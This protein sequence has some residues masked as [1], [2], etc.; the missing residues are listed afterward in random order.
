MD[1][2]DD[3]VIGSGLAALGTVLGLGDK[4]R[5]LVLGGAAEGAFSH[6]DARAAVPCAY[7]GLG[8]LGGYWHGVIPMAQQHDIAGADP[9]TFETLL[10]RFYPRA[11]IARHVGQA[12]LFVPWRPIRPAQELTLLTQQ[13][14]QTLT[15]RAA[16]VERIE[17]GP[18]PVRVRSTAGEH[19]ARRV[20]VAA[21]AMHTPGLL[22]RSFGPA[23]QR[24]HVADHVLCYVGQVDGVAAPRTHI[25]R[26]GV[27]FPASVDAG[28][29]A[30]YTIRPARFSFRQLDHGIEQR[31]AFGLPTGN[32]VAKIMRSMSPGLL[33]EAFYNRFGIFTRAPRYSIYAQTPV[34]R[35][36]ALGEGATPLSPDMAR[37]QA[38]GESARQRQP[39]AGATLS[40]RPDLY[41]PGIHLH[42]SVDL[43]AMAQAG[44]NRPGDPV[45]VVDASALSRIGPGH[46]SFRMLCAAYQRALN[47]D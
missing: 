23:L 45:Q 25:T 43:T 11:D 12:A 1:E 14:P 26:D 27:Y 22:A 7:S 38:A 13:R 41:I 44:I 31:A 24:S 5:V 42:H 21:G 29:T 46:H 37:I 17:A 33:A 35:A 30:L 4:R 9:L 28:Q 3:I 8:G 47:A 32:A 39:F 40:R 20:W 34:D 16:M 19:R 6:Y 15:V 36:Y 2:F 10:R 18:G